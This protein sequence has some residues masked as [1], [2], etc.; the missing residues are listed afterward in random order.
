MGVSQGRH[1]RQAG[2]VCRSS[3]Q[4]AGG[5]ARST[6][7]RLQ[8]GRRPLL[9]RI[10]ADRRSIESEKLRSD[11]DAGLISQSFASVDIDDGS[12]S[13]GSV[14]ALLQDICL[15]QQ[16]AHLQQLQQQLEDY[17]TLAAKVRSNQQC[18]P[19]CPLGVWG[20]IGLVGVRV[21]GGVLT[22]GWQTHCNPPAHSNPRCQP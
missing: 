12:S 4:Q 20:L 11:A 22:T 3:V 15:E 9:V 17:N 2:P 7:A 1:A 16:L 10:A 21:V 14:A 8:P 13:G 18:A 5:H 6:F 19:A